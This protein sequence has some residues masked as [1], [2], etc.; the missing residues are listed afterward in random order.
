[1]TV[2]VVAHPA[3][4]AGGLWK[5][6]AARLEQLGVRVE[7]AVS[8]YAGHAR[9]LAR[10]LSGCPDPVVAVGGDGTFNEVVNGLMGG[11]G[12]RLALVPGGTG[13]DFARALELPRSPEALARAITQPT[14]RRLDIGLVE[15]AGMERGRY[16][17]LNV[18]VGFSAE[19]TRRVAAMPR[20]CPGTCIYLM[21]L[22]VSLWSWRSR[23]GEL[24]VDG[25]PR[26]IQ[27][28]FNLNVANTKYYGGGMYSAPGADPADGLL[29]VV[30]M[31]IGRLA[32]LAA[33]P[34][35]YNGHFERVPGVW[36]GRGREFEVRSP[37]PLVVQCDG[38]V[39]GRTPA[40][41][42]VVPGGLTLLS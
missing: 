12:A 3:A 42:S 41:I 28:L 5:S 31:E 17:A 32:A 35:N 9:E 24:S 37:A 13:N 15:A 23:E 25:Q 2:R 7:V 18:T 26:S 33:L 38:D 30:S 20:L 29:D 11:S 40:R 22:L 39:V 21:S 10:A 4:L 8:A 16:F 36:Q 34:E 6:T 27:R 14:P 1:M 19:V